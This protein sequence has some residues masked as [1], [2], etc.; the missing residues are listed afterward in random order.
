MDI[1]KR[2]HPNDEPKWATLL[3][4]M[5]YCP[6]LHAPGTPLG[7]SL[8]ESGWSELRFVRIMEAGPDALP[9]L[10]RRMAQYLA[11]K[12]QPA[13]FDDVRKLLFYTGSWAEEIR[14][15]ISRAYY[16]TRYKKDQSE[17]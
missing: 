16:R 7:E 11:S 12:E 14:L 10:L 15:R 6:G 1:L 4:C 13:D 9:P 2:V 8:A 5:A 3:M 17:A